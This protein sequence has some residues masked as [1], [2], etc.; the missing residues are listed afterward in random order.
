MIPICSRDKLLGLLLLS[1]DEAREVDAEPLQVLSVLVHFLAGALHNGLLVADAEA[2]IVRGAT[3]SRVARHAHASLD[4]QAD[5]T[6]TLEVVATALGASSA[7][8]QFG[9]SADDLQVAYEW[10]A[11]GLRQ[12]GVGSQV[13]L[14]VAAL[15]AREASTVTVASVEDDPRLDDP[16]LGR[17]DDQLQIGAASALATPISLGTRLVGVLL[18][19]RDTS[20]PVW[21]QNDVR[22]IEG[23]ARELRVALET[24][25]LLAARRHESERLLAL[26][27]ASTE[28]AAA[29]DSHQAIESILRGAVRLLGADSGSYYR[30]DAAAGLLRR[31]QT[32]QTLSVDGV[33]HV[34][35]GEGLAGTAFAEAR[36]II[37][38]DYQAW[39]HADAGRR[40]RGVRAG[41][42][43]PLRRGGALTGV[44]VTVSYAEGVRFA[45]DD[46]RLLDL[47]GDQAAAALATA[48]S[49]EQLATAVAKLE[50]LNGVSA[51]SA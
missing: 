42:A 51:T 32:W 18:V 40:D 13:R 43:V 15:A 30:W 14:P 9:T 7:V 1:D 8:V 23:I 22:L 50:H 4:E 25:R 11:P 33:T 2:R 48:E 49:F 10:Q 3:I 28:L 12:L 16:A 47:F 24:A 38:N 41:L 29:T 45:A 35:P 46:A 26:H 31:M 36:P 20:Q 27:R 17:R 5:L 34:R 19:Q 44:L 21:T 37:V 39:E 6:R